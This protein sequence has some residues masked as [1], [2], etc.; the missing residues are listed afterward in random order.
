MHEVTNFHQL[1]PV[2][3]LSSQRRLRQLGPFEHAE[4]PVYLRRQLTTAPSRPVPQLG[5]YPAQRS[6][7][8]PPVQL[9]QI[10]KLDYAEIEIF[11][12]VHPSPAPIR[13]NISRTWHV[14]KYMQHVRQN[15]FRNG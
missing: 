6:G 15:D 4:L 9:S 13:Q 3:R 14:L 10:L 5:A 1:A 11:S 8:S 12:C 7:G 2:Q